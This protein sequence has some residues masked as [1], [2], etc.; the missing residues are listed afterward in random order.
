MTDTWY[1]DIEAGEDGQKIRFVG[2]G[3]IQLRQPTDE[4]V[5]L[6]HANVEGIF[7]LYAPN[8]SEDTCPD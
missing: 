7:N 4:I 8:G 3:M 5:N 2:A 6:A 1:L